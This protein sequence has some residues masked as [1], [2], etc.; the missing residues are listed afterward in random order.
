VAVAT[1]GGIGDAGLSLL[2][3]LPLLGSSGG[4][5]DP[6]TGT[7]PVEK[8]AASAGLVYRGAAQVD[9]SGGS[10]AVTPVL[11]FLDGSGDVLTWAEGQ[12]TNASPGVTTALTPVLG[13]APA[14]TAGV[15][16]T[17]L[18][19]TP[20]VSLSAQPA[21]TDAASP[22][23]PVAGPLHTAGNQVVDATGA[24]VTFRGVNY[25]GLTDT[26]TPGGFGEAQF[27]K[28]HQ[29]GFNLVRIN[30]AEQLY[31]AGSCQY[32]PSYAPAVDQAVQW[33]TGLGMVALLDLHM[34][35]PVTCGSAGEQEMA[36]T[37]GSIPFW[38]ALATRYQGNPL[39][40]F[41]LFNEPHDISDAV[42]LDGGIAYDFVP[43]GAA[44]MQQLYDTVRGTGAQNLVVV[45]G[46]NWGGSVPATLVQGSNVL[47]SV[48]DYTCPQNPPPQC[49]TADPTDP[50]VILDRWL[51]VGAQF[52][53]MVGEFGWPSAGDGT[54]NANVIAFAQAQHWSWSAFSWS[55]PGAAFSLL[56]TD[57]GT[58]PAE[59]DPS[60]M[61]V[62]AAAAAGDQ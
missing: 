58:G 54:Y 41:D 25:T 34:S 17:L 15:E 3:P 35:A 29:W 8:T 61:P 19:S 46:N 38:H 13:V 44:G 16:L 62:L 20:A 53:V 57:P 9:S 42:W 12:P 59:P 48:H 56:A 30:L 50:S 40:A 10:T 2:P 60:G 24:P 47:Y 51:A 55:G 32:D 21:I 49:T 52:P 5:G 43:Y 1:G 26:S 7:I 33:V 6:A 27:A 37:T 23:A 31:D 4:G 11:T 39:V 28:M 22:S 14:S 18:S 45:S 36:D